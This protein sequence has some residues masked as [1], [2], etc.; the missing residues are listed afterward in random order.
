MSSS[1]INTVASCHSVPRREVHH[2]ISLSLSKGYVITFAL[3]SVLMVIPCWWQ[4]NIEA[5]DL[6]SHIYNV[7]LTQLI[8]EHKAP[9][10][11]IADQSTNF[12]FDSLLGW[13]AAK[14]GMAAAQK[15]AVSLVVLVYFWAAFALVS[16]IAR[17]PAFSVMAFLAI[18]A[19]GTVF[20]LGLF[21]Y[22]LASALSLAS[23]ALLWRANFWTG[24]IALPL[25]V[26]AWFAQP[27]PPM[28]AVGIYVYVLIVR[29]LP[30]RLQPL[31]LL[32][33]VAVLLGLRSWLLGLGSTWDWKQV[34]HGTGLDQS[35]MF[36]HH[37]RVV[38]VSLAGLS[39]WL[40][41]RVVRTCR[42]Q[43]VLS[44]SLQIYFLCLL[45]SFLIPRIL[46]FPWYRA[47]FGGVPERL[48]WLAAIFLCA[49]MAEVNLPYWY[50]SGLAVLAVFYFVFLYLDHRAMNRIDKNVVNMVAQLPSDQR[51]IAK[52]SYPWPGGYD[53]SAILDR[54]CIQRCISFGNYEPATRQFRVRAAP[55]NSFAAWS[56]ESVTHQ[57]FSS[58]PDGTLFQIYQCGARPEELCII[59]LNRTTA[60]NLQR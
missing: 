60:D 25:L 32:L 40:I 10:L 14:A 43:L 12:L 11:W 6:P 26:L 58:V 28:W 52:L 57:Y 13:L 24:L 41:L 29:R 49:F 53:V 38:A 55:G 54:A 33:A 9:G 22:Y 31:L 27:L 23:L 39:T 3:V 36:G 21:N 19:Y 59:R 30:A 15:I 18:L 35:Y 16:V 56:D 17:K 2:G 20:N 1:E 37:F 47:Q 45:G 42:K 4:P 44:V 34:L 5:G 51:V 50:R 8:R 48:G 7:W 46:A